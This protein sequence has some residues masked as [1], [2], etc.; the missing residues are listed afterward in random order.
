MARGGVEVLVHVHTRT[1][2]S[3]S[4]RR[5]WPG[6][7]V[8]VVAAATAATLADVETRQGAAEVAAAVSYCVRAQLSG[9][10]NPKLFAASYYYDYNIDR[11]AHTLTVSLTSCVRYV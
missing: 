6:G 1:P 5:C 8:A 7:T 11:R 2:F 10:Q 3:A 9:R 4:V